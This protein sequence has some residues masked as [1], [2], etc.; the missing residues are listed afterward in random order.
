MINKRT[1]RDRRKLHIRKKIKGTALKPR[2]F[3]FRSNKYLYLSLADDD[4]G[5]VLGGV[6]VNKSIESIKKSES[7]VIK[8][9]KDNKIDSCVFDRS[10]YKFGSRLNTISELL[11]K[12]NINF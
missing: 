5:K 9:F 4:S 2:F 6:R 10:G 12:N 8:I 11:R 7:S 1:A 3:I